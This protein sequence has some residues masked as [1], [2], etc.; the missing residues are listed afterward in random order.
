LWNIK[1]GKTLKVG[2]IALLTRTSQE[3]ARS[4]RFT[5]L[6][7]LFLRCLLIILLSLLLAQPYWLN[8][9][10]GKGWVLME[11]KDIQQ[12]YSR[13]K[14]ITDS[15]LQAGYEFH[16]LEQD[17][18][19]KDIQSVLK[20]DK[21][22]I[23]T[24]LVSYWSLVKQLDKKLPNGFPVYLFTGNRLN[25]F[26]GSRPEVSIAV[27]WET[28]TG[29]DSTDIFIS[30]AYM[31]S[32]D[33]VMVVK[34]ETSPSNTVYTQESIAV[35]KPKQKDMVLQV[36]NGNLAIQYHN[37]APVLVDTATLRITIFADYVNDARY[38]QSALQ[39]IQQVSKRKIKLSV[40][41]KLPATTEAQDWLF[42]LSDQPIS[43]NIHA[44]AVF[45]YVNGNVMP[46]HSWLRAD[47][48]AT[49]QVSL[50]KRI[51]Y[52]NDDALYIWHDGFGKPILT[53]ETNNKKQLYRFYSHFDPSWN[54]LVWHT[55]F[56]QLIYGLIDPAALNETASNFDQR[57]ISESQI[58]LNTTTVQNNSDT[59]N[60][61]NADA[62][63]ILWII[64]LVLFFVERYFS[65]KPKK[66]RVYA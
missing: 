25:R 41:N 15:L 19:K 47:N 29:K 50:Y 33:S 65:F 28:F 53:K 44:A 34:G 40:T 3:H 36:I 6:F 66:E 11:K 55:S 37:D 21:D 20:D 9:G 61:D 13:F 54:D 16:L 42:W 39:S 56:P 43:R 1:Q 30:K 17:F 64:I 62:R 52:Q 14:P 23:Q 59:P 7:L 51:S 63:H 22:T 57:V 45:T 18:E 27:R 48:S 5:E 60:T 35:N 46:V 12:A 58:Q 26:T 32:A 8:K 10:S 31:T 24:N 38:L 49:I 2:S 4:L